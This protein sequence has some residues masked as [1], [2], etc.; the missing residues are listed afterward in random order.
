MVIIGSCAFGL[1]TGAMPGIS[2]TVAV[3]LLVP[4]TFYLSPAAALAAMAPVNRPKAQEPIIT[5]KISHVKTSL[6]AG[7]MFSISHQPL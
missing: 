2:A 1:F 6:M 7:R 3:A 4:V 5:S